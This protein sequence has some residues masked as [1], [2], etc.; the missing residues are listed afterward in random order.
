RFGRFAPDEADRVM[1]DGKAAFVA[2]GR[3]LLADPDLPNKLAAGRVDDVRPCIYQYRCI[4]NIYVSEPLRCVANAAT[5]REHDVALAPTNA[6]RH[7]LV[8]GGGAAGLEAAR[9]LASQG[10]R[11]T[12]R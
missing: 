11:V 6:P 12:L 8:A 9:L 4:G 5:G 7:V 3:K 2:M 10:Q 1:A